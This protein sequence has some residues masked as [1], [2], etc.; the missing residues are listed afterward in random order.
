MK[1]VLLQYLFNILIT[2]SCV[3]ID[4]LELMKIKLFVLFVVAAFNAIGQ[5]GTGRYDV[6]SLQL[7]NPEQKVY[8]FDLVPGTQ[9][10]FFD[11]YVYEEYPMN[12]IT[13]KL[14]NRTNEIIVQHYRER[15]KHLM[16]LRMG[17][18][19]SGRCDTLRPGEY[20]ILKGG[21]GN[22]GSKPQGPF[23][24]PIN[25]PYEQGDSTYNCLIQTWGEVY[26]VGHPMIRRQ[27]SAIETS[28]PE[29]KLEE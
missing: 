4:Y 21:W 26:P 16:W 18:S 15:D 1:S 23:S 11:Q 5:Y 27:H 14:Y 22:W 24:T 10:L 29:G 19:C 28:S 2:N 17:G 8:E 7:F 25:I 12:W 9:G 20:F 6:D 13:M 3:R